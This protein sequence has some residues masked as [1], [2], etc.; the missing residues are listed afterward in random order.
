[1]GASQHAFFKSVCK[2][3]IS[4]IYFLLK[5]LLLT[6]LSIWNA[7]L[8]NPCSDQGIR[9][10]VILSIGV[11]LECNWAR[12]SYNPTL[13]KEFFKRRKQWPKQ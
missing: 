2:Q 5:I 11:V 4:N 1:M 6:G 8:T 9:L 10:F 13:C 3:L 7:L 12:F